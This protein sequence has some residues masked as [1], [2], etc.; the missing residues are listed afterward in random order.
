MNNSERDALSLSLTSGSQ[1]A[2]DAC[3]SAQADKK[4]ALLKASSMTP[5]GFRSL[6]AKITPWRPDLT[7]CHVCGEDVSVGL[8]A[9][10]VQILLRDQLFA[11]C[12][13]FLFVFFA[14]ARSGADRKKLRARS[15]HPFRA[16]H[17]SE[18]RSYIRA[19]PEYLCSARRGGVRP[20]VLSA[21]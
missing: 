7:K 5:G 18:S 8:C 10:R 20:P 16:F 11:F 17:I 2:Q 15:W 14:A 12:C 21:C 3:K 13:F 4:A 6:S 19:A 9:V 1:A